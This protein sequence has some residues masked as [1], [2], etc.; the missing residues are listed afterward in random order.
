MMRSATGYKE[1]PKMQ[2]A[3]P[4]LSTSAEQVWA[5]LMQGNGRFRTGKPQARDLIRER[6]AVAGSQHPKA[7]VLACADS[8]VAP[9]IIFDQRLGDLFVVRTAGNVADKQAIGSLEYAAEHLGPTIF[10]VM[11]HQNCGGVTA[12]CASGKA[13]S[14]NLKAIISAIRNAL[15]LSH[16]A[17]DGQNLREAVVANVHY[18][19]RQVLERSEILH[20]RVHGGQLGIISAYY[21]LDSGQVER[22]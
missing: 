11:G 20:T 7:I 1:K 5:D 22:V 12:A 6:E 19:A 3:V 4:T 13:P 9:E 17:S 8:R 14:A 16:S 15:P 18:V 10:V 21:H 2:S